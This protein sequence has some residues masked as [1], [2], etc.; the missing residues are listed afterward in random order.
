MEELAEL[1]RVIRKFSF[2]PKTGY[3]RLLL[4]LFGYLGNGKSS[5]INTCKYVW[6][7]GEFIN[8]AGAG[9]DHGSRTKIR[10]SFPLTKTITLVDNRG[11]ATMDSYETGEIYAQLGNLLPLDKPVE[12]S[13]GYQ[14][15]DRIKRAEHYV[16]TS[17]FIFP[18]FVYSPSYTFLGY[19]GEIVRE[20]QRKFELR[21]S[22]KASGTRDVT[23][24]FPIVVLTQKTYG[25]VAEKEKIF[26]NLG[27]ERIFAFENYSPKDHIKT[28][29]R[30]E[31]V[32]R[33]L[34]EVIS[35]VQFRLKQKHTCMGI[36]E[37]HS[38]PDDSRKREI[39]EG[40]SDIFRLVLL[41]AAEL[42]VLTRKPEEVILAFPVLDGV[43]LG[44]QGFNRVLLQLFGFAGHGKSSFINSCKY[45]WDDGEFWN[46]AKAGRDDGARTT[47]RISYELTK[48]ITLVDNRGCFKMDD[49][50][51]G[52]IFAQLANLLPV[53]DPVEW[54]KGLGLMD[55]IFEAEYRINTSDFIVPIFIYRYV[56]V[57]GVC[58][59]G[60]D[61]QTA[62]EVILLVLDTS[63]Q[64]IFPLVV[65]THQ[66]H[67][68]VA[69]AQS[70]FRDMGVERIFTIENY[71]P[72]DHIKTRG[73]HEEVLNILNE[74]IK[75]VKF[76]MRDQQN[77][78]MK[79]RERMQYMFKYV[80][81][82]E[83]RIQEE[84]KELEKVM[85]LNLMAMAVKKTR[86]ESEMEREQDEI[87]HEQEKRRLKEEMEKENEK[88]RQLLEMEMKKLQEEL[89]RFDLK[90][91][92]K[93]PN[94]QKKEPCALQ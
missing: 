72:E 3:S 61:A 39:V 50:E 13:K 37:E 57:K 25:D 8:H 35:D 74:V 16:Q 89:E 23:R 7:E 68:N 79:L 38:K 83:L 20:A 44:S 94:K 4:Q 31:D 80:C 59:C 48:T 6:D 12:W 58:F 19:E 77:P 67:G 75:D 1:R 56:L 49:Y 18:I 88:E 64:R 10:N 53:D 34:H 81:E 2:D 91:K 78:V 66:T 47:E 71:T 82:R 90:Y 5:F 92:N 69:K 84:V 43:N 42:S 65:L 54:N 73:R 9:N 33:F 60:S 17:D 32:L 27:V 87:R 36:W 30:H 76:R 93:K 63:R 46:I 55:R 29:G 28:R 85:Q 40:W 45:V 70:L 24:I 15:V 11:C 14:L 22:I 62:L 52:E 26:R 86:T 51:K 21:S 41:K